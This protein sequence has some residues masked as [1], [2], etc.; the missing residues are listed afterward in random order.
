M[1]KKH[2]TINLITKH[3]QHILEIFQYLN[4]QQIQ[5]HV[6]TTSQTVAHWCKISISR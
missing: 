6:P 3:I 5:I 1:L 4:S 2:L